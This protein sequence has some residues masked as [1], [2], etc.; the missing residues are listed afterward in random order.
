[1]ANEKER[2]A[3]LAQVVEPALE[4]ELPIVDPHH[5]LWDHPSS[6]YLLDEILRDTGIGPS[7][8]RDRV[9]R[10]PLDVSRG[11]PRSR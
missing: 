3:W 6:R 1:M 5:H 7:R 8:A 11:R 9:R 4:P 10:M 2:D